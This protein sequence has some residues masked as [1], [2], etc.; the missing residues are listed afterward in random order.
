MDQ[1]KKEFSFNEN[2]VLMFPDTESH[3]VDVGIGP[4]LKVAEDYVNT[5]VVVKKRGRGFA[6]Q[7]VEGY[8]EAFWKKG[9]Q[10]IS[11][12][13]YLNYFGNYDDLKFVCLYKDLQL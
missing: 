3:S 10:F 6:L 8:S 13:E 7:I 4:S 2:D 1:N 9:G 11:L 12:K 5:L